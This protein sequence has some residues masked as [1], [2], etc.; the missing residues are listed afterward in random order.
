MGGLCQDA[1]MTNIEMYGTRVVLRV[2]ELSAEAWQAQL[3]G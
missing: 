2:R 1:L 3:H